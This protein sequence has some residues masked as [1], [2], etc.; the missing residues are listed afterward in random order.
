M[1]RMRHL[2]QESRSFSERGQGPSLSAS[3]GAGCRIGMSRSWCGRVGCLNL[4][5]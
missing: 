2:S 1:R 5:D 4:T 3:P